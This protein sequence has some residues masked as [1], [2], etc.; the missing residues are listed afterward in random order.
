MIVSLPVSPVI[1]S[2]TPE[3]I[4][5]WMVS[6]PVPPSSVAAEWLSLLSRV[7]LSAPPRSVLASPDPPSSAMSMSSPDPPSSVSP[8]EPPVSVSF[9]ASPKRSSAPK[10]PSSTSSPASPW[11]VSFPMP[12][13]IVSS[14]RPPSTV[15]LPPNASITSSPSEPSIVLMSSLLVPVMSWP[16]K[17]VISRWSVSMVPR[18]PWCLPPGCRP[19]GSYRK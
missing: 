16:T 4:E 11:I 6:W 13:S 7:S 19:S 12:P 1:V 8:P 10:L 3:N 2:T 5:A 14:P 17:I 9:P 18:S 15:S